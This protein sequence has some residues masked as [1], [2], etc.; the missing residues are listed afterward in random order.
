MPGGPALDFALAAFRAAHPMPDVRDEHVI[1][2][3]VWLRI[4]AG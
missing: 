2:D 1:G 3:L 4:A